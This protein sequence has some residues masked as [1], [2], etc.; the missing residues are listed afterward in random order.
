MR[1]LGYMKNRPIYFSAWPRKGF[2]NF[3]NGVVRSPCLLSSSHWQQHK[4][5]TSQVGI[6]E[7]KWNNFCRSKERS[8]IIFLQMQGGIFNFFCRSK[9]WLS[10]I[11][12]QMQFCFAGARRDPHKGKRMK[13]WQQWRN[14]WE[15]VNTS[16]EVK[17]M[18]TSKIRARKQPNSD[19]GH[20]SV[21]HKS[22]I[23]FV[24]YIMSC[25]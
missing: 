15:K 11:F 10:N 25:A 2:Q 21:L 4:T 8:S 7:D 1:K 16:S 18:P 22:P 24:H 23:P 12:L 17:T 20:F 13:H 19:E 3:E 6:S 14:W 9:D 5:S